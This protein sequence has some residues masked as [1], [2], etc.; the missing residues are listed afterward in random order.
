MKSA[1]AITL[2]VLGTWS[3]CLAITA[4][5]FSTFNFTNLTPDSTGFTF[6]LHVGQKLWLSV[7]TDDVYRI[8]ITLTEQGTVDWRGLVW[9]K[10]IERSDPIRYTMYFH[11]LGLKW[12][13]R[14]HLLA[15]QWAGLG[16]VSS[17]Q[18]SH[19]DC[20]AV[21]DSIFLQGFIAAINLLSMKDHLLGFWTQTCLVLNSISQTPNGLI[22]HTGDVQNS[23]H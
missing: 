17:Q 4:S 19:S 2:I 16:L 22:G 18:G 10:R 6:D 13:D 9:I 21:R 20:A 3:C 12:I 7:W 1:A 14:Q 15:W 8:D 23:P 11:R 5:A